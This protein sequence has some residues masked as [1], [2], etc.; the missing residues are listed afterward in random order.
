MMEFHTVQLT[1][2][3]RVCG[4]RLNKS[5]GKA[6]P[7]YSCAEASED[8]SA[9]VGVDNSKERD[10]H[11]LPQFFCHL[12]CSKIS[13]AK[14]SKKDGFPFRAIVP[15]EWS[16]HQEEDCEVRKNKYKNKN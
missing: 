15:K 3:C 14:K 8:L 13:S 1:K 9:I 10:H 7:V 11:I 12:C 4:K 6:Q 2:H 5:K 16:S